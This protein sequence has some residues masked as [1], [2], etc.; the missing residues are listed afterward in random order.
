MFSER[1]YK[2]IAFLIIVISSITYGIKFNKDSTIGKLDFLYLFLLILT[3]KII[4]W[5][6][7]QRILNN[8]DS[9]QTRFFNNVNTSESSDDEYSINENFVI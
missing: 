6:S 3:Y 5:N 7:S 8:Y 4:T 2:S 1:F 9:Y